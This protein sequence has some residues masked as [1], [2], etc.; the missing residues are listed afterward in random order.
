MNLCRI[1]CVMKHRHLLH[2]GEGTLQ[3]DVVPPPQE[4][5][6]EGHAI[7]S[8]DQFE[9][10]IE[11]DRLIGGD[12]ILGVDRRH[13]GIVAS[14][15]HLRGEHTEE[16]VLRSRQLVLVLSFFDHEAGI[17]L[18]AHSERCG[19]V[20][21]ADS[22]A[23]S[24]FIGDLRPTDFL[25]V[26]RLLR[27]EIR[28][29]ILERIGAPHAQLGVLAILVRFLGTSAE[30]PQIRILDRQSPFDAKRR[31]GGRSPDSPGY[32]TCRFRRPVVSAVYS[33]VTL[34]RCGVASSYV[35]TALSVSSSTCSMTLS[36]QRA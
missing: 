27:H 23:V 9:I 3:D 13:P 20:R 8:S 22:Q 15:T 34:V 24:I 17:W 21:A 4:G 36:T 5:A 26:A 33:T 6:E 12:V 16:H 1:F 14:D 11:A 31:N 18:Q 25:V 29:M 19:T 32:S 28:S 10:D 35:Y 30:E 7:R 2:Q